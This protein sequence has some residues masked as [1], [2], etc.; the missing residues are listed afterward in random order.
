MA[1]PT[2]G[3]TPRQFLEDL[4]K[5]AL[6]A[7]DPR[8]AGPEAGALRRQADTAGVAVHDDIAAAAVYLASDEAAMVTGVALEVDGGRCI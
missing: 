7:A 1:I 4:F 6:A 8:F 2:P 3:A 5:A